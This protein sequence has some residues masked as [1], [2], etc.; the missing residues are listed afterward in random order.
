[1]KKNLF[2]VSGFLCSGLALAFAQSAPTTSPPDLKRYVISE[3]G[4]IGDA[5]TV[6][7]AAIQAAIDQCAAAGGGVI[8]VPKGTFISGALYFK[9]GVN[10]LVEK[11]AVLKS[12]ATMADFRPIYTRWEGIERYW[13]S[14]FLNFINVKDV[15]VSGEGTIDGS[16]QDFG[17]GR[18]RGAPGAPGGPA[19]VGTGLT[20]EQLTTINNAFR[21][22]LS[23]DDSAKAILDK[24]PGQM[25]ITGGSAAPAAGPGRGALPRGATQQFT[26]PAPKVE[27]YYSLPLPATTALNFAPDPA[28]LPPVNAAGVRI[29]GGAGVAPPRAL[30]FQ[31][32]ENVRVS[33]LHLLNEARWGFVFI[34]CH[35][36]TAENLTAFTESR[37]PSSDGMDVDSCKGVHIIGCS[38]DDG[39]DDISIKSGKDEDGRRV[40]IPCE[41]I[42]IEKCH[43]GRGDGGAAMGSETSGGIRNVIVRDCV[44]DNGNAAPVRIKTNI[45]R[46]GVIENITYENITYDNIQRAYEINLE[47]TATSSSGVRLPPTLRNVKIINCSGTANSAGIIHGV[48]DSLISNLT[49]DN[50]HVTTRTGLT[51]D[52]VTDDVKASAQG[53]GLKIEAANGEPIIWRGA[54]GPPTGAEISGAAAPVAGPQ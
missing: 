11:D 51:I 2:L 24:Y 37:I 6:N 1:M 33:G 47:W 27:D 23:S 18:G 7:T 29:P 49:F 13:T 8:V 21:K 5:K 12:T 14:A 32:C 3:L 26:G 10:L 52:N 25:L 50:C 15:V 53:P 19:G 20:P 9:Q 16:G 38:F 34:Y 48:S 44:A 30:V 40:N 36:V 22:M 42:I 43:F 31:N 46:G 28:K 45:T 41:D 35:N 39:D 4:A 54:V 17:G